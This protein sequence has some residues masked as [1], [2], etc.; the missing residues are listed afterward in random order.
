M[1]IDH[2]QLIKKDLENGIKKISS[3]YFFNFLKWIKQGDKI[4]RSA[5]QTKLLQLIEKL[6]FS[7]LVNQTEQPIPKLYTAS[8]NMQENYGVI[9]ITSVVRLMPQDSLVRKD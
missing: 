8:A 9:F 7:K 1:L 2:Y 6:A 3:C 5:N 4:S